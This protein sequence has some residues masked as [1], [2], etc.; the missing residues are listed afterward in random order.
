MKRVNKKVLIILLLVSFLSINTF[1]NADSGW[2]ISYDSGSAYSNSSS[3]GNSSTSIFNVM[4]ILFL[5]IFIGAF[6]IINMKKYTKIKENE[7]EENNKELNK[8]TKKY[9]NKTINVVIK[10]ITTK[11]IEIKKA[12]TN[13]D[14]KKL[15]K[16]CND[17][18]YNTYHSN[19]ESLKTKKQKN[20]VSDI[21]IYD[22]KIN[23]ITQYNDSIEIKCNI[24]MLSYD[25]VIN[26][27]TNKVI[28]G[29]NKEKIDEEYELEFII[30]NNK[31]V[32][33]CPHCNSKI[34]KGTIKC[35]NC[36][37]TILDLSKIVIS[38]EKTLY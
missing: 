19:L 26:T 8:L 24:F 34:N 23:D 25:Y 31:I 29:T 13:F 36:K 16:L 17:E 1:V 4:L 18:M 10:E 12:Y 35:E 5:W 21:E 9:L 38:K 27:D 15:K 37:K 2:N 7:R 3:I 20:I 11:F 14:Y 32:S 28:E 33:K 22:I 30:K 6:I